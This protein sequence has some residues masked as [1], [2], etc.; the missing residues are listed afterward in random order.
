MT[1]D[2]KKCYNT[3]TIIETWKESIMGLV[4]DLSALL[5]E[6]LSKELKIAILAFAAMS[7]VLAIFFIYQMCYYL[8]KFLKIGYAPYSIWIVI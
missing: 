1:N 5:A 7:I 2:E 3:S 4:F 8:T 6:E